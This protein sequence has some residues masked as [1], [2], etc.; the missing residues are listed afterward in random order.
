MICFCIP[1]IVTKND[2][3]ITDDRSYRVSFERIR[4]E[5]GFCAEYDISQGVKEIEML[6]RSHIVPDPDLNIYSNVKTL[7]NNLP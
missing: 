4:S 5:L 2:S 6:V 1:G 7:E 3:T